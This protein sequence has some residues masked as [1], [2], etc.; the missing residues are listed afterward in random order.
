MRAHPQALQGLDLF[1]GAPPEE[2]AL[3]AWEERHA[4]DRIVLLS[5]V[6][7]DR[8][9][10]LDRLHTVLA[11]RWTRGRGELAWWAAG[12]QLGSWQAG[13]G[14]KFHGCCAGRQGVQS[15]APQCLPC[16]A[17]AVLPRSVCA[18]P[19]LAARGLPILLGRAATRGCRLQP[20]GAAALPVCAHG[21]VPVVRRH[22]CCRALPTPARAFRGAGPRDQPVPCASGGAPAG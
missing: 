7:L 13:Q 21:A 15:R 22:R 11:G 3:L 16:P 12:W 19:G 6:W 20:A 10:V 14:G 4:G 2:R 18:L 17:L 9:D 1:G 8:P 5:D